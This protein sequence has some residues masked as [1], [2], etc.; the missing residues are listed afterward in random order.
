MFLNRA[1]EVLSTGYLPFETGYRRLDAVQMEIASLH[2]LHGINGKMLDW[3]MRQLGQSDDWL[4]RQYARNTELLEWVNRPAENE[5]LGAMFIISVNGRKWQIAYHAA[6]DI[7]D[8][9]QFDAAGITFAF[10]ARIG[11]KET[12]Y[13]AGK[14]LQVCRDTDFGCEVRCRYWFGDTGQ[15]DQAPDAETLALVT[16]H[17]FAEG[18]IAWDLE[19]MENLERFLPGIYAQQE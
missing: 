16:D 5:F 6:G 12:P 3:W 10:S 15:K 14:F 13:W 8:T 2:R 7:V 17:K 9:S 4:V 1:N 11:A 18:M 19:G